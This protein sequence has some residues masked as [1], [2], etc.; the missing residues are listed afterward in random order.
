MFLRQQYLDKLIQAQ[1]NG[2]IKIITGVRRCGKSFLLFT[3]FH[4]YLLEHGVGA[5]HIIE[6]DLENRLNKKLRDPDELLGYIYERLGLSTDSREPMDGHYYVLLDEVQ[7]VPEFEDVLNSFLKLQNVD[8]YVTGSNAKFLSKDVITEFR[9]RGWEIRIHPLSFA[10]FYDYQGGDKQDAFRLYCRYGGLPQVVLMNSAEEKKEYL[11][12]I[13]ETTY[14][15]DVIERNH[16]RNAEGLRELVRVLASGIGSST[17][18]KRIAD[19][20]CSNGTSMT[21]DTIKAYI[22]HL[23]DAFIVAEAMRYDVKGRKYIGTE[24]KYFFEDLGIR[25]VVLGFRQEEETHLMENAIYNEL[26]LRGNSVDV[27]LVETW[28]QVDD[29]RVRKHLEVDFV[30]NKAPKRWYIQSAYALPTREKTRQEQRSL[31]KIP[32]NFRKVIVVGTGH[33][34]WVN[35]EGIEILGLFDFMLHPEALDE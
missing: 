34:G 3:L 10:E 9:G 29:K 4:N 32:D 8:V 5:N 6:V 22:G 28:E 7:L 14:L 35:E 26:V 23:T 33:G 17:N 12:T 19:T 24:T 18:P 27:G 11:N 16:L 21:Q 1:G 31:V 20:F 15:R 25:N 2:M 30:V 13:F